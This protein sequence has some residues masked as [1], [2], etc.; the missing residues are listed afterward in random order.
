MLSSSELQRISLSATKA[1]TPQGAIEVKEL[2]SF[3]HT[4]TTADR[5]SV[6]D[7]NEEHIEATNSTS[8]T[9][10]QE[11][12]SRLGQK[13]L[14]V[15][16]ESQQRGISVTNGDNST[17]ENNSLN[18]G[19][20]TITSSM[21]DIT[22]DSVRDHLNATTTTLCTATTEEIVGRLSVLSTQTNQTL[23]NANMK[24]VYDFNIPNLMDLAPLRI[25]ER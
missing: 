19:N 18:R 17:M 3:E 11:T 7:E 20:E 16:T 22:V 12:L 1:V 9:H 6:N 25:T 15:D 4:N 21:G 2:I 14:A 13:H 8:A 24:D 10:S 23:T 5:S